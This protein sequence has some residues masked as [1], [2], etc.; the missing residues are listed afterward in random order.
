LDDL[1]RNRATLV[2]RAKMRVESDNIRSKILNT[3]AN[4][5]RWAEVTPAMFEDI[6]EQEMRKFEK[7]QEDLLEQEG[8]QIG[9]L[10]DLKVGRFSSGSATD[11]ALTFGIFSARTRLS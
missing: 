3:A 9:L 6:M 5:E 11:N 2:R 7:F 8:E 10:D 1:R 4:I